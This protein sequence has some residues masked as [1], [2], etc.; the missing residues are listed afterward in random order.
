MTPESSDPAV[1]RSVAITVEDL[2]TALETNRTSDK[3][4]VLRVTPPFSGRM[5]ARLHVEL[6][7]EYDRSPRPVHLEPGAL[8]ENPPSYP[9][10]ADTEDELRANPDLTYSVERH[11]EYHAEAVDRWRKSVPSTVKDRTDIETHAGRV[12]VDIS[13]LGERT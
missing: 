4:A 13:V 2:V 8:V 6:A 11:H 10:P 1:I 7:G 12:T 3:H 5:R 9:R